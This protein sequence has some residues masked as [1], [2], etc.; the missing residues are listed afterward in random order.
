M[1]AEERE[2]M[3]KLSKRTG[4]LFILPILFV[5]CALFVGISYVVA[6]NRDKNRDGM[7]GNMGSIAIIYQDSHYFYD[8]IKSVENPNDYLLNFEKL[9]ITDFTYS[10]I[11]ETVLQSVYYDSELNVIYSYPALFPSNGENVVNVFRIRNQYSVLSNELDKTQGTDNNSSAKSASE[12]SYS[13]TIT[14]CSYSPQTETEDGFSISDAGDLYIFLNDLPYSS[15]MCDGLAEY[16]IL[17]DDGGKF[18]INV[19]DKWV[20]KGNEEARLSE[21]QLSELLELMEMDNGITK[22][23]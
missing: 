12:K 21:E 23:Q 8:G 19:S 1:T 17:F 11:S 6:E 7:S 14:P 22:P 13:A 4:V 5:I 2:V 15:V 20:W 16:K 3:V 10:H 9:E 18:Y